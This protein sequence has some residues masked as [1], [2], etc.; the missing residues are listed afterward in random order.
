MSTRRAAPALASL[1]HL[2]LLLLLLH[3][4]FACLPTAAAQRDFSHDGGLWGSL[5]DSVEPA[6][7][8]AGDAVRSKYEGL[9]DRGRFIAGACA[10][11]GASRFAVR[12]T[13]KV[14]KTVGAA[15][16]AFEALEFAGLLKDARSEE[17][18]KLLAASRDYVL[19]TVDGLRH[20]IRTQL[21]PGRVQ[22]MIQRSMKEDRS[23]TVG[24]GTGAFL[25]FVL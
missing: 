7:R 18:R 2:L 5:K 10:G 3:N 12:G 25:G 11:F 9:D 24:L 8:S 15:Y 19:R 20:D 13:V 1:P 16:I 14:V 22:K 21:N 23:G 17:S 6:C 4:V